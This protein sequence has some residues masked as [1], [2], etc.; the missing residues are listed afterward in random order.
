MIGVSEV[1][2]FLLAIASTLFGIACVVYVIYLFRRL[3]LA[4]EKIAEKKG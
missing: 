1:F 2:I 4:A 3:V